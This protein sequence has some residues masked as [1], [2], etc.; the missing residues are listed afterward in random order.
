MEKSRNSVV[1]TQVPTASERAESAP[2]WFRRDWFLGLVLILFVIL[3]YTP[4]WKA[5]FVWDDENILTANP[6][7]V[8]PLGLKEIWTTSAA[9]VC[10]LTLTTF[11][12]EHAFWGLN[13]LPYHV[14]N[15]L[16]HGLSAV[17]LWRALLSLRIQGAWLGAALWAL[18]PVAVESVAWITEMKNTESG[19]FFLLS[20]LF[21][22]RWLRTKD[23]TGRTGGRWSYALSLLFAALAMAAKSSTVILPVVLCLCAWW[24]EGRWHWRN[25]AKTIPIFLMA[26]AASALSIWTQRLQLATVTDP[27]W[28]RTWPQRLATAGDA[29]WFYLGK[30]LWPHPLIANYPRWRID[31]GQWV[32]C[33][34]L[35]TVIVT[36]SIFW[37]R[38]APWSRAC[39]FAFA[40]FTVA[41]LP[42]LGLID[43][44][45]F[46]YS[47]VFDHFQYLA[48]IGPL[49]LIGTALVRLLNFIVPRRAWLQSAL[50]AG[51]LL[52]IGLASWQHTRVYESEEAL[53]TDTLSTNPDSWMAY[54]NLGNA[55]LRRGQ[56]GDA[57]THYEKALEVYP[58]HIQAR[59]N[60]GVALFQNGRV[61][62]AAAQLQK[63]VE[64]NP[65]YPEAHNN[66]GNA[67][68]QK[69]QLD[70]AIIEFEK[71][72]EINPNYAQAH[73]NLGNAL[74]QKG[75]LD[76]A[77]VHYQAA[78]EINP[79]YA[80][81]HNNLGT[82]LVQKGQLDEA[83]AQF[84]KALEVNCNYPEAHSNLGNALVQKGQLD[85]ALA[86]Y[87]RAL[88]I[89]PN[90]PET[91]YNYGSALVKKGELNSAITEFQEVLRLRPDFSAAQDNL[92][93][94]QALGRQSEGSN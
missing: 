68:V 6:C 63:A 5:G 14:V 88:V 74:I 42:A 43:A 50:G 25:L 58:N 13:P 4:V 39:F 52:I 66:L 49:A 1:F 87:K 40:Y 24:I 35:L 91:H 22:V 17:V 83:I 36:L 44:Y 57:I 69:G 53:W 12:A 86:H 11:W 93:K 20:I 41:L 90:D 48:S 77:V 33:L 85:D 54:N 32:S 38:R 28:A 15:V 7:I 92:A 78:L 45:I 9:D 30:L 73:G 16:L 2:S 55:L 61:D 8:G 72:V 80:E 23:L 29:V 89:N 81:A 76:D 75:Q 34:P 71:A 18:H 62:D 27:Q 10:P 37:L 79:E 46:Q 70:E 65:K 19:L 84:Q 67:L 94:V 56:L 60:L 59:S 64:I 21:F 26:M 82:A 51:L 47:F 31:A 3:A